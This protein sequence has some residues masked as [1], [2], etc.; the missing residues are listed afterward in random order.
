MTPIEQPLPD[1]SDT[2]TEPKRSLL[3]LAAAFIVIALAI[4]IFGTNSFSK[5]LGVHAFGSMFDI[6]AALLGLWLV[7]LIWLWGRWR[8]K[9]D[10][11]E[12]PIWFSINVYFQVVANVWLLQ[13]DE[14]ATIQ[15]LANN[16]TAYATAVLLF[17]VGITALWLGYGLTFS[18]LHT[19][20]RFQ[21]APQRMPRLAIASS[22]WIAGTAVTIVS[23]LLGTSTFLG[24]NVG[25]ASS[26][27]L[28]FIDLATKTVATVLV[29]NHFQRPTAAGRW[30]L[31]AV[32]ML[33]IGVGLFSGSKVFLMDI[34]WLIMLVYYA[35]GKIPIRWPI[36]LLVALIFLVPV[37]NTYRTLLLS[38]NSGTGVGTVERVQALGEALW[39]SLTRPV[40]DA[41]DTSRETFESRQGNLLHITA[42]AVYLHPQYVS[43]VGGH[44]VEFLIP[45]LV[46][47]VFWPSKPAPPELLMRKTTLYFG[48]PFETSLATLGQVADSYRAAGWLGTAVWH[49]LLGIFAAW[50]YIQGP[51]RKSYPGTVFSIIVLSQILRY[52]KDMLLTIIQMLQ[53]ATVLWLIVNWVLFLPDE[54]NIIETT[55]LPSPSPQISYL[56][57]SSRSI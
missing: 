2:L 12:P 44:M 28:Y 21:S 22:A 10:P 24:Q 20:E 7:I 15:W 3:S 25:A 45:Q 56:N 48:A 16:S 49:S 50:L 30:W 26:N 43:Y 57:E 36:L 27:Y 31:I 4:V 5:I 19:S 40:G 51:Y 11:F 1:N 39:T 42:S 23:T 46:P 6:A 41:V 38:I 33:S 13:R 32:V 8:G 17:G 55:G 47:R 52:D 54:S 35:K 53:F 37:V 14:P 29:I 9:F 34:L 18:A